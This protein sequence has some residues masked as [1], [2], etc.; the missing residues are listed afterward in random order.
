MDDISDA[1]VK[2]MS[3][4]KFIARMAMGYT[5][6]LEKTALTVLDKNVNLFKVIEQ[7]S[8]LEL[9]MLKMD[10]VGSYGK[11]LKQDKLKKAIL[12]KLLD[13]YEIESFKDL[14][15]LIK[16]N[17]NFKKEVQR[18]LLEVFKSEYVDYSGNTS[19]KNRKLELFVTYL[20]EATEDLVLIYNV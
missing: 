8:I 12:D 20:V 4:S 2:D 5:N 14:G 17:E 1:Q 11:F 15:Y 7:Y 10:D 19:I 6:D 3:I 18:N 16:D 13:L 9:V